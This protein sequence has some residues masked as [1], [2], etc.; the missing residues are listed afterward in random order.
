MVGATVI[1]H[2]SALRR[3]ALGA[4]AGPVR[5]SG[6]ENDFHA[7][8]GIKQCIIALGYFTTSLTA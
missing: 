1:G 8:L 2:E 4:R 6:S 7:M 3:F 5:R